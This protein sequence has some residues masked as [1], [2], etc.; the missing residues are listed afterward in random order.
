MAAGPGILVFVLIYLDNGI[1]WHLIYNPNNNLQH[2]ESYNWD[3]FL[4]GAFNLMSGMLGLPWLVA[5]TVPCIVHLNNLAEKDSKGNIT[6]VQETRLTG[7]IAHVLVGV[8]LLLLKLLKMI[9]MPV[10]LGVFLFMGLSSMPGIQFWNRMLLF[11]QQPSMYPETPFTKYV[12]TKKIHLYTF[13]QILFFCGVFIVQNT[14]SIAIIF[15]FM[16]LLCIPGRL[17][18]LPKFFEGWELLLLDGENEQID[19]WIHLREDTTRIVDLG[20]GNS[21]H[22]LNDE[23]LEASESHADPSGSASVDA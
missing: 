6:T 18:L 10:L 12:E 2:G 13:L 21:M 3:L 1:T 9:P 20:M 7:L 14:K 5:T 19:E 15:P 16:T 23:D 8:S 4:N 22:P 17:F 11:I